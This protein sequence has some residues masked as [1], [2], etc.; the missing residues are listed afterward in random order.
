MSSIRQAISKKEKK[1]IAIRKCCLAGLPEKIA[2]FKQMFYEFFPYL[3]F[4][5]C[6]IKQVGFFMMES[7][8]SYEVSVD[9]VFF[10]FYSVLH[11]NWISST[12]FSKLWTCRCRNYTHTWLYLVICIVLNTGP[13]SWDTKKYWAFCS[14]NVWGFSPGRESLCG[15][16][17]PF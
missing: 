8:S 10:F 5:F 4:C 13:G 9:T 2:S 16:W 12:I 7:I 11:H 3:S 15:S 1:I 17:N 14:V 6:S